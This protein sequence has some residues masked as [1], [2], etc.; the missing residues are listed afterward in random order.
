MVILFEA[1]IP[2]KK[3]EKFRKALA[4]GVWMYYVTFDYMG[5]KLVENDDEWMQDESDRAFIK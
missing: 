4:F 2:E 5:T 3:S 1:L